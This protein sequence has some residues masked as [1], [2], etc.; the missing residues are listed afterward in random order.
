MLHS[1]GSHQLFIIVSATSLNVSQRLNALYNFNSSFNFF[2]CSAL[3]KNTS[4]ER[5]SINSNRKLSVDDVTAILLASASNVRSRLEV[6]SCCHLQTFSPASTCDLLSAVSSKL[7]H[8]VALRNLT[9]SAS[10]MD[11]ADQIAVSEV[12]RKKW[13]ELT[14]IVTTHRHGFISFGVKQF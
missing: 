8:E 9:L 6:M 11:E 13:R 2:C 1:N 7:D 10:M 3:Q 12:W 14:D 5:L 4:L